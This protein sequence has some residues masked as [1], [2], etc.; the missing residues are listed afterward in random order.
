MKLARMRILRLVLIV[1]AMVGVS[2]ESGC[3]S[4]P[5]REG[6]WELN[7]YGQVVK[8]HLVLPID[9]CEVQVRVEWNESGD[10]QVVEILYPDDE[11][12]PMYGE[13]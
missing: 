1:V 9:K 3:S 6:I 4:H 2:L 5:M 12:N 10:G 13:R 11:L 8:T 7:F